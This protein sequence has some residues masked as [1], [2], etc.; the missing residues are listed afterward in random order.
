[1]VWLEKA[2]F[3]VFHGRVLM[4]TAFFAGGF[5]KSALS[6]GEWICCSCESWG[7]VE[8]VLRQTIHVVHGAE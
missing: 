3:D 5:E 2:L 7:G 6:N 8:K 4:F 1:M